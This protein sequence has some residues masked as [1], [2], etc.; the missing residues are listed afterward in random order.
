MVLQAQMT[1]SRAAGAHAKASAAARP[2]AAVLACTLLLSCALVGGPA[3]ALAH[4][5]PD[6]DRQ[7]SVAVTLTYDGDQVA[8]GELT[9]YRVGDV[10]E[11]D[12]DYG[13]APSAAF[14]AAGASFDA[15]TLASASAS[16]ALADELVD[17]AAQQGV[18]GTAVAVGEDGTALF[19]GLEPGL[20]LAVQTEASDGFEPA[21]PFL[22]SVPMLEDGTYVYDVDA[23]PKVSTL[24]PAPEE[25]PTPQEP[26]TPTGDKLPQTGQLNWP[27]PVLAVAGLALFAFGWALRASGRRAASAE[28]AIGAHTTGARAVVD[29]RMAVDDGAV[30]A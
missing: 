1:R 15:E 10:H 18:S 9:L 5:V 30:Q 29:A 26:E 23:S 4:D 24:V 28:P 13:F 21:D 12:G 8:G 27:I 17:F 14:E 25:P 7:G 16:A 22:V 3:A 11:D 6:M 2:S 19:E 20:Y